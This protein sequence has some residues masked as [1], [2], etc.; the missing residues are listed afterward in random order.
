[1][2]LFNTSDSILAWTPRKSLEMVAFNLNGTTTGKQTYNNFIMLK[3][4]IDSDKIL[5]IGPSNQK[6]QRAVLF[7]FCRFG[8]IQNKK[9]SIPCVSMFFLRRHNRPPALAF[10][11]LQQRLAAAAM[12]LFFRRRHTAAAVKKLSRISTR[13]HSSG[14]VYPQSSPSHQADL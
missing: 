11:P 12:A 4:N 7:S 9:E 13:Y 1:M 14:T 10:P 8:S 3:T 6:T 5:K 2:S